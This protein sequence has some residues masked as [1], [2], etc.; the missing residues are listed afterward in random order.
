MKI[1]DKVVLKSFRGSTV[2]NWH[3][4]YDND[5]GRIVKVAA[6]DDSNG[7]FGFYEDG[8]RFGTMWLQ[9]ACEPMK[10]ERYFLFGYVSDGNTGNTWLRNLEG[11]VP[12]HS[13]VAEFIKGKL[14]TK[15]AA[16][17]SI[18]EFKSEQDYLDFTS[19][20]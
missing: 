2:K 16:V 7:Q 12:S 17:T 9:S 3:D 18:F 8:K 4:S 5:V 11:K 6:V 15:N 10:N 1:G 19:N 20:E 13:Y 14:G